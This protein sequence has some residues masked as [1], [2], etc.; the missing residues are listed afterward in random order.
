MAE[1]KVSDG[2]RLFYTDWGTGAPVV[3]VHGWP[4][5]S[6]MWE[7][8]ATFLAQQ[9]L[10]VISYYSYQTSNHWANEGPT[11]ISVFLD[12]L[13]S[14]GESMADAGVSSGELPWGIDDEHR[15]YFLRY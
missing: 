14:F 7:Y 10:R 3:L 6:A 12:A 11:P 13:R 9:G 15:D 4:L 8:Q 5:S 1:L 2:T